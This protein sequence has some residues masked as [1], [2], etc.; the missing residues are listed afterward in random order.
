MRIVWS[1]QAEA[2]GVLSG[3]SSRR[4]RLTAGAQGRSISGPQES[5]SELPQ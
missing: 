4:A 5:T 1:K 3:Q 2:D